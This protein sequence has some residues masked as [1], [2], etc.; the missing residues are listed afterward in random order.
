M[1]PL[2]FLDN[3]DL[4]N[5]ILVGVIVTTGLIVGWGCIFG[6]SLMLRRGARLSNISWLE[7]GTNEIVRVARL[8]LAVSS[9]LLL[10]GGIGILAYA[11]FTELDLAPELEPSVDILRRDFATVLLT[12][13][14]ALLGSLL[15]VVIFRKLGVRT[16]R[17][18]EQILRQ[19]AIHD[20]QSAYVDKVANHLPATIA[21]ALVFALLQ[22]VFRRLELPEVIAWSVTTLVFVWMLISAS[23]V[24]INLSFFFTHGLLQ[25]A[26]KRGAEA[27]FGEIYSALQGLLPFGQRSLEAIIYV[28]VATL[29]VRRF[30]SLEAFA[31]YGPVAIRVIA[32]FFVASVLVTISEMLL[33]RRFLS[34]L[35][36]DDQKLRRR[37]TFITLLQKVIRVVIYF[38]FGLMALEDIGVNTTPILA[39]AGIVGLAIGLGSQKI[40]EDL[41]N[42]VFLVFEDQV[43]NGDY[44]RVGETEGIVEE[45]TL[46]VT[47]IRDRLG[48]V[49]ILRNSEITNVINY[50]RGWTLAVVSMSVAYES[51][52]D[53]ALGVIEKA[54]Q[55]LPDACGDALVGTPEVMGIET[56]DE[57]CLQVRIETRVAPNQHFLVKRAL[58]RLLVEQF[59]A[60]GLEIPYP[61]SVELS[62]APPATPRPRRVPS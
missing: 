58:N 17:S 43:L 4:N 61:K 1:Q 22:F 50:S 53:E 56:V 2:R 36:G 26:E 37:A 28:A 3:V 60:H 12:T 13:A 15:A 32:L 14:A 31:P 47:R 21:F 51:D 59:N 19:R 34:R 16:A 48:R 49:H 10:L 33:K 5:A 54:C 45:L 30:E 20:E 6:V 40:V 46:R 27:R 8:L 38:C 41:L 57:S 23:Q 24:V 44:V 42:G 52:L 25:T 9:V 7:R 55:L 35:S 39:S 29:I 11:S 62:E 18:I